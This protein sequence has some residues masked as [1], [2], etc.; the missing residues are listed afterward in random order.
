[1]V[2]RLL[3]FRPAG[4]VQRL[5]P[6]S[7]ACPLSA[8]EVLAAAAGTRA[9]LPVIRCP[10]A[11][12]ARAALVAAQELRGAVGLALPPGV[13][14]E[15]WFTAVTGAADEVAGGLPLLLS[16][17][18]VLA[19]EGATHVERA[20]GQVW[21]LVRAGLTHLAVDVGAVS[22]AERGRIVGELLGDGVGEAVS[23]EVVVPL[24]DGAQAGDRAA[25]VVDEASRLGGAPVLL[26]V[27]CPA[28]ESERDAQLQAA[29]LARAAR[30]LAGV[31]VIRRGPVA[32]PLPELLRG[33]PLGGCED[34]GM[35]AARALRLLPPARA[36]A[37]ADGRGAS[38]LE[39]AAA[40]A[41][42]ELAERLEALA[43][44]D[45]ADFLDRLGARGSAPALAR[46]L[47]RRLE[48][49]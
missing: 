6:R 2:P 43:Y 45:A 24:A 28:P 42:P 13:P 15:P 11:H 19:G 25:A 33:S 37:A 3:A 8:R 39:R 27:R 38:P 31:A 48:P 32:G 44:V 17:E 29:A 9:V 16:G 7:A 4:A 23:V 46:A 34:G 10:L 14:P 49:R 12:V 18:V 22:P 41:S 20:L 21:R 26:G 1:M 5:P 30:A 40:E 36:R 47:E 35:V